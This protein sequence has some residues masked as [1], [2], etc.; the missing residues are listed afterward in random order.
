MRTVKAEAERTLAWPENFL[1]WV[2]TNYDTN[3]VRKLNAAARANLYS[4]DVWKKATGK[5]S[6][7]L[8]AEWKQAHEERLAASQKKDPDAEP[9]KT[10][11]Q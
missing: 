8:G 7:E 6:P 1:N 9:K 3:I 5:T 10:P 2:T 11:A 4:E